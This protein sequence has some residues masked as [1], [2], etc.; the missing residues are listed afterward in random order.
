MRPK[1][2]FSNRWFLWVKRSAFDNTANNIRVGK[3]LSAFSA[4]ASWL[5]LA[6]EDNTTSGTN[7]TDDGYR[8]SPTKFPR[9]IW[10]VPTSRFSMVTSSGIG[11]PPP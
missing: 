3:S 1:R 5:L 9:A 6:K 4:P 11:P 8:R 10:V 2:G 7:S